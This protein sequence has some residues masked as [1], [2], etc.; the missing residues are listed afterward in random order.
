[1]SIQFLVVSGFPSARTYT[2]VHRNFIRQ[3]WNIT[4]AHQPRTGVVAKRILARVLDQIDHDGTELRPFFQL[5]LESIISPGQL[6]REN[7]YAEVK[8]AVRQLAQVVWKLECLP[9]GQRQARHLLDTTK[10][11]AVGYDNGVITVVLN[12]QLT[13]YLVNPPHYSTFRLEEYL[14]LSNWYSMR[15]YELLAAF[16]DTG[17]WEVSVEEY[18][19][20]MD[21]HHQTDKRDRVLKDKDGQPKLKYAN[22]AD[23]I[24]RTTAVPLLDLASTEMAFRV[25]GLKADCGT[26]GRRRIVTLRFE[27]LQ[28]QPAKRIPE[29]WLS[30]PETKDLVEKLRGKWK[31][32][33]ASIARYA[34]VL[35][36]VRIAKLLSEWELKE[37]SML[38]I[39]DREKYCNAVFVR[40]AKALKEA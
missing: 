17:V 28:P 40:A 21:C 33:E 18:R 38:H 32:K 14:K 20:L 4:F 24:K 2:P 31:V 27:L 10:E 16:R 29:A 1:M 11:E 39:T 30:H 37:K 7:A 8:A 25:I 12:P 26:Q 3:H 36:R 35:G 34:P 5:S 23:L 9:S 15:L 6:T 22:V 19:K 13:T